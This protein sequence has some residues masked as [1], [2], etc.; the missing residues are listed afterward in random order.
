MNMNE[1]YWHM[2][3]NKY[4]YKVPTMF[5]TVGIG[6]PIEVRR[7]RKREKNISVI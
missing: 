1:L 2:E 4:V 6:K 5:K 7:N 3:I